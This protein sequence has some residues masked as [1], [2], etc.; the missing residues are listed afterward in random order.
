MTGEEREKNM[1]ND[2]LVSIDRAYEAIDK[3]WLCYH[4]S[5]VEG[6][7][8]VAQNGLH[9]VMGEAIDTLTRFVRENERTE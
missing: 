9:L 3:L 7:P 4:A 1:T 5:G 6:L 8:D 2:K